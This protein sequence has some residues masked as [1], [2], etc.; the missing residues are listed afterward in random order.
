M[1]LRTYYIRNKLTQKQIMFPMQHGL[2]TMVSLP[3]KHSCK[4]AFA[5]VTDNHTHEMFAEF[6]V[7]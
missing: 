2:M 6:F 1:N 7:I 3:S 5:E 4:D